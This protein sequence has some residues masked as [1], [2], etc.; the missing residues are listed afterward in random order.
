MNKGEAIHKHCS[1][2]GNQRDEYAF[3]CGWDAARRKRVFLGG[4]CNESTWRDDLI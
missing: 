4:T 1:Q 3:A 2:V